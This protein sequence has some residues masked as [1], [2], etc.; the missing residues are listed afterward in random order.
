M[1]TLILFTTVVALCAY[2]Y[3]HIS[4]KLKFF[5]RRNIPGPKPEFFFGNMR[6]T[7]FKRRHMSSVID[8]IYKAYKDKEQFCGYFN[9]TTPYILLLD[10][11][12]VK[13]V[14]I[15][16][17]R[18]FRNNEFSLLVRIVCYQSHF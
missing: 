8:D 7:Y 13:Q 17:F 15:K 11:E 1:I 12:L 5:E 14:L 2:F 3:W 10:P 9:C 6:E 4:Q 16:D 18:S